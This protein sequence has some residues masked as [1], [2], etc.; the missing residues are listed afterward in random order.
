MKTMNEAKVIIEQRWNN[1]KKLGKY[2]YGQVVFD[3][4]AEIDDQ[5]T[6]KLSN[7]AF[8]C[9]FDDKRVDLFL[10]EVE[11]IWSFDSK[12]QSKVVGLGCN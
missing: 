8:D 12:N 3:T 2:R 9:F 5:L 1:L 4:I 11:R 6:N 7:T 10:K